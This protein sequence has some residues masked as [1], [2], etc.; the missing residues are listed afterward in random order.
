MH[1][2]FSGPRRGSGPGFPPPMGG[3]GGRQPI[4]NVPPLTLGL[5]LAIGVVFALIHLAPGFDRFIIEYSVV[6]ARVALTLEGPTVSAVAVDMIS[7]V[8]HALIHF[9]TLHLLLNAGF[10]LAFGSFCERILGR[11][12]YAILLLG[13][14]AGGALAQILTDWGA[15]LVMYGASGAVS[16]CMAGM[17]RILLEPGITNPQRQRFALTFIVVLFVMNIVI[18]QI[19]PA[20]MG[21]SASIAWEAHIGGFV[22]GFLLTNPKPPRP[23]VL[24]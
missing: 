16:G 14:A 24:K 18:G 15:L 17:V 8:S 5:V 7:L 22:A 4:F 21:L 2:L 1:D 23:Q 20:L 10:L 9:E 12:D 19:G 11:K 6:P 3:L 13:S